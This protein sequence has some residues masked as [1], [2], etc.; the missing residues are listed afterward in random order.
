MRN[1]TRHEIHWESSDSLYLQITPQVQFQP[2]HCTLFRRSELHSLRC[3]IIARK[4][5]PTI[6]DNCKI[7]EY[8]ASSFDVE[9][10]V[11]SSNAKPTEEQQE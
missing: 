11:H 2:A 3:S 4:L 8:S 5:I 10:I 9:N 1:A 6:S 7:S